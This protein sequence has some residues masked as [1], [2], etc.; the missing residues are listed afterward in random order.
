MPAV[1]PA[2]GL[3]G[4]LR[5]ID[6]ASYGAYRRIVGRHEAGEFVIVVDRVPP[7]PYAG[8]A[9]VRLI[10]DRGKAH[11]SP[12]L[13]SSRARTIGV[14]DYLARSTAEALASQGRR[15][16]NAPPGSGGVFV[17]P[18]GAAMLERGTCRITGTGIELRL[19]V[20][21]PAAGRRVL[22]EQAEELM[23]S[24][25]PRLATAALLFPSRREE[26]AARFADAAE[27]HEALKA[28]LAS[29]GLVAFVADGSL[30]AR[31]GG[32]DAGPR[33]DGREVAFESPESLAVTMHL[34]HA[35]PVRGMGIPAGVTLIVGGGFHGKSTLL[36]AIA[37]GVNPHRPGD[38]RERV[39]ALEEAVSVRSDG[40]RAVRRVDVS[41]FFTDLPSGEQA[42][43]FST[44]RASGSTSLAAAIV[45]ATEVGARLLLL[46]EDTSATN[47]MI[48]DGRMQR[49]VPR[50]SEPIVPFLDRVGELHRRLGVSTILVTGGSGDYLEAADTV[51]L[52]RD[53]R[54]EDATVRAREVAAATRSMRVAEPVPAL[55]PPAARQPIVRRVEGVPL[56][57]GLRGP[58]G[59]R[60]GEETLDLSAVEPI[61]ET[62]QVK[63]LALLLR[64][65]AGRMEVGKE[66]GALVREIEAWLDEAG[67]DALDPPAAY[68][69]ARPRRF[70]LAAAIN[71]WRSLTV[72][73]A[74]R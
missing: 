61:E 54:A 51:I 6:G 59:V 30:L 41:G 14:E 35:G 44:E 2:S 27:D 1:A 24:D 63:A 29:R 40:G 26:D 15:G 19:L 50:P 65:A 7:D 74:D 38:G 3:R 67:L 57:V 23:L 72:L 12:R 5:S 31:A 47:F 71:R 68:D 53:Y 60:I 58:R 28:G 70:D 9:R 46:D 39:A 16:G 17:E 64:E 34:P 43:D 8:P 25:L 10:C 37:T 49:L 45:E 13:V 32:D 11:L 22:G 62:G 66:M 52:M 48:R 42:A 18:P 4:L 21:L 55:R 73:R 33:R 20:D 69:L 36:D 56:R